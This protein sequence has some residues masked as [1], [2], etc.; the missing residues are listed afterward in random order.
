MLSAAGV[1]AFV[2]AGSA[3]GSALAKTYPKWTDLWTERPGKEVDQA[4]WPEAARKAGVGG[5]AAANCAVEADGRLTDCRIVNESPA[6]QGFGKAAISL[7]PLYRRDVK[8]YPAERAII[9]HEWYEFDS[10]PDWKK[11]PTPADLAAVFPREALKSGKDGQAIISCTAT[12]HGTLNDCVVLWDNPAGM[13]FGGAAVALTP[14]FLMKP[15]MRGGKPTPSSVTIPINF[16]FPAGAPGLMNT[17]RVA[18]AEL[19]WVEAPSY[20]DVVAAYP[21]KAR[22]EKVAG[23]VTL[24]CQMTS[25]GRLR[26]CNA[27]ADT[28]KGYGFTA[29][30]KELARKFRLEVRTDEGRNLAKDM[31]VHLPFVFDPAMLASGTPLIGKPSWAALPNGDDMK[32][33][34][35]PLGLKATARAQLSCAVQPTGVVGGCTVAAEEP[36]GSGVGKA[37][38]ALAPKFRLTTW[39]SEGLPTVGGTVR[40]PLRFE[41]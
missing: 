17:K 5:H 13:G 23:R 3:T 38:L 16:S 36:A 8:R 12:V 28:P 37:A 20:A 11:K 6:G 41:P 4:A 10:P 26:S 24:N 40:I 18:P 33:V 39:T 2:L 22:K 27:L 32:A 34:I 35:E 31:M 14:Q 21:E 15:A 25:E 30:A 29:A 19:A 9:A 7:A 1:A